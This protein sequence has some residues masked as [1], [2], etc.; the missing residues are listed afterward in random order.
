M[1]ASTKE[2]STMT[3]NMALESSLGK[4]TNFQP[5]K[6]LTVKFSFPYTIGKMVANTMASGRMANSMERA[7]SHRRKAL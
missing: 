1:V 5:S 4:K 7:T 6:Y 3:R 2:S